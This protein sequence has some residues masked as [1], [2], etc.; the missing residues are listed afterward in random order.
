MRVHGSVRRCHCLIIVLLHPQVKLTRYPCAGT[1]SAL[2]SGVSNPSSVLNPTRSQQ[3]ALQGGPF[4]DTEPGLAQLVS[5]SHP[6]VPTLSTS[7]L[8]A[9]AAPFAPP[10]YQQEGTA[11]VAAMG[12]IRQHTSHANSHGESPAG[13]SMTR[14]GVSHEIQMAD[15]L[16]ASLRNSSLRLDIQAAALD[17]GSDLSLSGGN[18]SQQQQQQP[19]FGTIDENEPTMATNLSGDTNGEG[20]LSF[21]GGM[22]SRGGSFGGGFPAR[23][24]S[25]SFGNLVDTHNQPERDYSTELLLR[26]AMYPATHNATFPSLKLPELSM[27]AGNVSYGPAQ[28][29]SDISW[30]SSSLP[31]QMAGQMSR[32]YNNLGAL[33]HASGAPYGATAA[34]ADSSAM[35]RGLEYGG[36]NAESSAAGGGSSFFE[37][38]YSN[39]D[40]RQEAALRNWHASTAAG[41][42]DTS[43]SHAA[44]VGAS[45]SPRHLQTGPAWDQMPGM[46]RGALDASAAAGYEGMPGDGMMYHGPGMQYGGA[47][48]G[49]ELDGADP[50][51]GYPRDASLAGMGMAPGGSNVWLRGGSHPQLPSL[52]RGS[53]GKFNS[54]VTMGSMPKVRFSIL[55]SLVLPASTQPCCMHVEAPY[56]ALLLVCIFWSITHTRVTPAGRRGKFWG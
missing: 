11:A 54:A 41:M 39:A 55:R 40:V 14:S 53:A 7:S 32:P 31:P 4:N 51:T 20:P 33:A 23:G 26:D 37:R 47:M 9:H 42:L 38:F 52:S 44:H 8:H 48:G 6:V 13:C 46:W 27:D 43:G 56:S 22:G 15:A 3:E 28:V 49:G 21:A 35:E 18:A 17:R 30:P 1:T 29:G 50:S 19:P 10:Q 34:V 36:S 45:L 2:G 12:S 24:G 5:N 16:A 25:V